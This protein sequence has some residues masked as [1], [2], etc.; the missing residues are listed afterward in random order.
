MTTETPADVYTGGTGPEDFLSP[1]DPDE[2]VGAGQEDAPYGY[3]TDHATGQVRP[4]LRPGRPRKPPGADELAA[5]PPVERAEDKPPSPPP[6]GRAPKPT[7]PPAEEL[8][9]PKGGVI[10]KGVNK[11]YRGAGKALRALDYD[12]G[13]AVIECTRAED[14]EDVTVGEAWEELCRTNPRI[15]AFVLK[16]IAGGAYGQ[17][18]MAHLPIGMAI[19]MKPWFQKNFL[20][21]LVESMAEADEDT[22]EGEGG[23]PGGMTAADAEQMRNLAEQQM[24]KAARGMGVK[25]SAADLRAARAAADN[26][27]G[28]GRLTPPYDQHDLPPDEASGV[29]PAFRR[30]QP[31]RTTRAQRTA[32]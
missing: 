11:L 4:K 14:A 23:L 17:L 24:R 15:R 1:D 30:A 13:Q 26:L 9:M 31:K 2:L 16:C 28:N 20:G 29:P 10:A 18:A 22:P 21:R 25:L 6:P 7:P 19:V 8:P 32:K 27:S 5:A 3:T 12:T